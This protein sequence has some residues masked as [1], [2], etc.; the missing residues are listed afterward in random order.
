MKWVKWVQP[1]WLL[2]LLLLFWRNDP[3]YLARFSVLAAIIHEGGHILVYYF[4]T[5]KLPLLRISPFGMA[6]EIKRSAFTEGELLKLA[7]AGP[8]MNFL[9]AGIMLVMMQGKAAY[10][11]YCF[12]AVNLAMGGFNLLPIQPLDGGELL[13]CLSNLRNR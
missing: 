10:S 5:G 13:Q 12:A 8:A 7:A 3:L 1:F 2:C 6:M 4:L 9:T 11:G